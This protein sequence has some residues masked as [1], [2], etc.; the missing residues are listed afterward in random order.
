MEPDPDPRGPES[1]GS[2]G[3]GLATLVA[4]VSFKPPGENGRGSNCPVADA[5]GCYCRRQR[6]GQAGFR[7]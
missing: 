7:G 4:T 1:Y 3:S 5:G 2:D 6:R